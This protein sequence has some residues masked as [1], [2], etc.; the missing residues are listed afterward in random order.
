MIRFARAIDD[1]PGE[2][3]FRT[4]AELL[5]PDVEIEYPSLAIHGLDAWY[6]FLLT[7]Q[8]SDF[9]FTHHIISNAL[10]EIDGDT[11][12]AHYLVTAAHGRPETHDLLFMGG[13]YTQYLFRDGDG[14]RCHRH[15][16][17]HVWQ[18]GTAGAIKG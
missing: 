12:T 14:W 7:G 17:D 8:R 1:G 6:D 11:A 16:C 3:C 4:M 5:T 2:A 10:I 13:R 15:V 18:D 9:L